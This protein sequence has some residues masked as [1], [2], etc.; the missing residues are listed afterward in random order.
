M[1]RCVYSITEKHNLITTGPGS[2]GALIV[3]I[4]EDAKEVGAT[5]FSRAV[6]GQ[7]AKNQYENH[8]GTQDRK[9]MSRA[10]VCMNRALR[11]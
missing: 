1:L 4:A 8:N 6:L 3:K 11:A 10:P 2:L 9:Q 5:Q 7:R